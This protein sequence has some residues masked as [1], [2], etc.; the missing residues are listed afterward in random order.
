MGEIKWGFPAKVVKK[1]SFAYLLLS[2]PLCSLKRV[3]LHYLSYF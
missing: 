3:I 1:F 2:S